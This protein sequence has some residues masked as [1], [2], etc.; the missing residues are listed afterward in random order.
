MFRLAASYETKATRTT[1]SAEALEDDF[2]LIPRVD[3]LVFRQQQVLLNR[4]LAAARVVPNN[5]YKTRRLM[6]Y[7]ASVCAYKC[8]GVCQCARACLHCAINGRARL[9]G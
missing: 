6:Y 7:S 1:L 9:H 4:V 5:Q 2:K 8:A 3:H